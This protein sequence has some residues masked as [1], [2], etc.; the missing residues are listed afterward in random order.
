MKRISEKAFA[1]LCNVLP[2]K[3]PR[4]KASITADVAALIGEV[5]AAGFAVP[6]REHFFAAPMRQWRFDLAWVAEK[7]A[8]EREGMGAGFNTA[9][10]HQR[11]N[12]YA[13]DCEKYGEAQLLGWIVI[14][15][16]GEQIVNGLAARQVIR[17]LTLRGVADVAAV[18]GRGD[19][20]Q[21]GE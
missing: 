2:R 20:E 7:V 4:M 18:L 3:E 6:T 14:R 9:G 15:G 13:N 12:G 16:T 11:R 1:R 21:K 19:V 5:V 17:A 10:R 8:F